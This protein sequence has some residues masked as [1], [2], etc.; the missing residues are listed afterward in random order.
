MGRFVQVSHCRGSVGVR[1]GAGMRRVG[2]PRWSARAVRRWPITTALSHHGAFGVGS[3][4]LVRGF[5]V[6]PRG[7]L[8]KDLEVGLRRLQSRPMPAVRAGEPRGEPMGTGLPAEAG[9]P[10]ETL[11]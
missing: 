11:L 10:T 3:V 2:G 6:A 9:T 8:N 5:A 7:S 4:A 1:A